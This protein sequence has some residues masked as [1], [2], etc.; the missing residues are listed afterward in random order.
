MPYAAA[1][2]VEDLRQKLAT[3]YPDESA[4]I[5]WNVQAGDADLA[6]RSTSHCSRR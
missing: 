6:N 3:D 5:E 2:F 4:K 1:D